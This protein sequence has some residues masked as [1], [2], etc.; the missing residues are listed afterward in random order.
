MEALKLSG[1]FILAY[2]MGSIPFSQLIASAFKPGTDLR[3]VGSANSGATNVFVTVG[4]LP[5]IIALVLDM[6][7]GLLTVLLIR[8]I[9][10]WSF[11]SD[12]WRILTAASFVILGHDYSL[13]LGFRGGKGLAILESYLLFFG[14]VWTVFVHLPQAQLLFRKDAQHGLAIANLLVLLMFPVMGVLWYLEGFMV[15]SWLSWDFTRLTADPVTDKSVLSVFALVWM[16]MF[17]VQRVLDNPGVGDDV[18]KGVS[19]LKAVM[20]RGLYEVFP[21]ASDHRKPSKAMP[22]GE[23]VLRRKRD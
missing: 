21:S 8:H 4:P 10:N 18:R 15:S 2:L 6:G 17:F 9:M 14:P 23:E 5:G 12:I 20:L 7:K 1:V 16:L 22:M 11:G 13:F 19:P 3:K